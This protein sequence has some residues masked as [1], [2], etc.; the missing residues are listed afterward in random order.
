MAANIKAW[1]EVVED[2]AVFIYE[3]THLDMIK[4]E[5]AK[6]GDFRICSVKVLPETIGGANKASSIVPKGVPYVQD[7]NQV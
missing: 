5:F 2:K 6:Q 4:L 3:P 1:N 7:F